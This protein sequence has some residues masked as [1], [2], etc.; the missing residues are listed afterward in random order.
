MNTFLLQLE[1][2]IAEKKGIYPKKVYWQVDGGPEN[3]NKYMLA[4]CEYLV[5]ETPIEEI[6]LTRLPVG[7][8]HEDIDARFGTIWDHVRLMS[9]SSPQDY[10]TRLRNA[11]PYSNRNVVDIYWVPNY[12]AFFKPAIDKKLKYYSKLEDTKLQWRFQKTD[13]STFPLGVKTTYR[14]FCHDTVLLILKKKHIP[15]DRL[16]FSGINIGMQAVEATI[17]WQPRNKISGELV[18]QFTLVEK[19][20]I[21]ISPQGFIKDSRANLDKVIDAVNEHFSGSIKVLEDWK[22]WNLCTPK[23][24]DVFDYLREHRQKHLLG[25]YLGHL[26]LLTRN[27]N[28]GSEQPAAAVTSRKRVREEKLLQVISTA[29]VQT[30]NNPRQPPYVWEHSG[31]AVFDE[32]NTTGDVSS[33]LLLERDFSK[34][35]NAELKKLLLD[36]KGEFHLQTR[37]TGKN[38]SELV[39]LVRN[40]VTLARSANLSAPSGPMEVE[41]AEEAEAPELI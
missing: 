4:L 2:W 37:I 28:I 17:D 16:S 38:K 6:F 36:L 33:D 26:F 40:A 15:V 9:I 21:P 30:S 1:E 10:E 29:S 31:T 3:A 32:A 19:P 23:T 34:M 11:F 41:E 39:A 24:D 20:K 27:E 12:K 22:I 13:N 14:A 25:K 18:G 5:S 7:H 8:T 35:S